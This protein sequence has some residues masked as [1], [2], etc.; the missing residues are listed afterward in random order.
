MCC[1]QKYW[2][3]GNFPYM[4]T[5]LKNIWRKKSYSNYFE[6]LLSVEGGKKTRYTFKF[7]GNISITMAWKVVGKSACN[8]TADTWCFHR[9]TKGTEKGA[10]EL[11]SCPLNINF[12]ICRVFLRSHENTVYL[13]CS[14]QPQRCLYAFNVILVFRALVEFAPPNT[15]HPSS[16]NKTFI[17]RPFHKRRQSMPQWKTS[18]KDSFFFFGGTWKIANNLTSIINKGKAS[19]TNRK[20]MERETEAFVH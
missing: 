8:F 4:F 16:E 3:C 14:T 15:S 2:R 5:A 9:I 11:W 18:P 10:K 7:Y 12:S 1:F 17:N 20:W 6:S 19:S 13:R